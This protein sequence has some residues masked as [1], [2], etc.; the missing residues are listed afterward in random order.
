MDNLLNRSLFSNHVLERQIDNQIKNLF[1]KLKHNR[2]YSNEIAAL[3]RHKLKS[4]VY[5]SGR[6]GILTCLKVR[7][8]V[9]I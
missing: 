1:T 4:G 5:N 8:R 6:G 7:G 3:R 2:G 9:I